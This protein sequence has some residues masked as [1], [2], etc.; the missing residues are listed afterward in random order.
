MSGE[1]VQA[2]VLDVTRSILGAEVAPGQPLM[3]AGL[4]SLGECADCGFWCSVACLVQCCL[5]CLPGSVQETGGP[6]GQQM[7]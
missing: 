4:D 5:P 1:A 3:D 6:P 2:A 7:S